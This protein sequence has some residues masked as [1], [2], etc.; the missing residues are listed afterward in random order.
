MFSAVNGEIHT[1]V[2]KTRR[3]PGNF[4]M[5]LCTIGRELCI[6]VIRICRAIV[7]RQMTSYTRGWCVVKTLCMAEVAVGGNFVVSV[8]QRVHGVMVKG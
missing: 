4:G 6:C 5:A 1:I 3:F 2:V 8:L 7:I